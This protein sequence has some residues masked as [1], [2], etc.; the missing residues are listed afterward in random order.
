MHRHKKK[1]PNLQN[2]HF[3]C[4][5]QHHFVPYL[6]CDECCFS[7]HKQLICVNN[8]VLFHSFANKKKTSG[9]IEFLIVG[10]ECVDSI[11]GLEFTR[12]CFESTY[13]TFCIVIATA[14]LL[15]LK[16][17]DESYGSITDQTNVLFDYY[18]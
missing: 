13:A 3:E 4:P 8:E 16:E 10:V 1:A 18:G 17:K 2:G 14:L 5:T 7:I 15:L 12:K 11:K 6:D 9:Q